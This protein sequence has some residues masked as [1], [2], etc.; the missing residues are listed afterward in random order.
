MDGAL[1]ARASSSSFALRCAGIT[2]DKSER[3]KGTEAEPQFLICDGTVKIHTISTV[4]LVGKMKAQCDEVLQ[5]TDTAPQALS[6][7]HA[8]LHR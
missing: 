7:I 4:V 3:E 2:Q 6:F 8:R 5:W 1:A